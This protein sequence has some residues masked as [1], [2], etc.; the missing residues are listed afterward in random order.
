MFID[1][2]LR[3]GLVTFERTQ[4]DMESRLLD[5]T[6][7]LRISFWFWKSDNLLNGNLTM[8]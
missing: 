3:Y 2:L 5:E 6:C 1:N 4:D 8:L 7:V